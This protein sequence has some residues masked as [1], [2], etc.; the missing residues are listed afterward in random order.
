MPTASKF[1]PRFTT[2]ADLMNP[3]SEQEAWWKQ[4]FEQRD[5]GEVKDGLIRPV[6]WADFITLSDACQRFDVS[7]ILRQFGTW[8]VTRYGV[9]CLTFYYPIEQERVNETD[10][11]QHM[12]EKNWVN[13]SDFNAAL[14][15]A[16]QLE[17]S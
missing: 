10:W 6:D 12:A 2:A 15:Y 3:T 14:D 5:R 16:R 1:Q 11:T 9:E 7:P 8:A 17:R 4:Q 13:P